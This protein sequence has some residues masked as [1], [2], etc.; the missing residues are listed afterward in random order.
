MDA[1]TTV[2]FRVRDLIYPHPLEVL[3]K[4]FPDLHVEGEVAGRTNDGDK[5][6]L[7]VRLK[8]LPYPVIVPLAKAE[9]ADEVAPGPDSRK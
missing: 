3:L 8:E 4:M 1:P 9:F 6:F 7:L 2:R 5:P